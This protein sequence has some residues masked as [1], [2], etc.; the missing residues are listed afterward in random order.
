MDADLAAKAIALCDLIETRHP[1]SAIIF[2]NT[3]SDTEL[4]EVYLRRRGFDARK[5]NS[6]LSQNE[7]ER[8]MN[9]V[10]KGTLR[11]LIATDVAARGIDIE[12]I[13]LVVNYVIHA[14]YVDSLQQPEPLQAP[15]SHQ[16]ALAP[17]EARCDI[18]LP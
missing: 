15:L 4:V 17:T 1:R 3:K 6:D 9:S 11:L 16:R 7:R 18:A 14:Q 5:I 12:Q 13:D 10:R 2:C 8:I